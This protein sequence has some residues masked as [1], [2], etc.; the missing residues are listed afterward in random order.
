MNSAGFWRR[1]WQLL[2]GR[3]DTRLL[4]A[5]LGQARERPADEL[6]TWR[7]QLRH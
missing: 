3:R 1:I 2:A 5:T 6:E 4:L 7:R